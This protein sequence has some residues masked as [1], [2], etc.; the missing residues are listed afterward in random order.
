MRS[1]TAPEMIVADVPQNITWKTKKAAVQAVRPPSR[2]VELSKPT[3]KPLSRPKASVKPITANAKTEAARSIRFFS[4]TL[5]E[6]FE[7]TS[8][9]SS[10]VKPACIISTR[11]AATSSQTILRLP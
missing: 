4:A 6:F 7:R 10:S 2:N 8:P 3:R 5:I 1:A 11:A 9:A